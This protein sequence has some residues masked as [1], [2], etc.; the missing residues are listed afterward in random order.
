MKIE[1]KNKMISWEYP[2]QKI[3]PKKLLLRD[4]PRKKMTL[5]RTNSNVLPLD[6]GSKNA[7]KK[8]AGS[9]PVAGHVFSRIFLAKTSYPL[10]V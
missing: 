1:N 9:F 7:S 6:I 2:P 3:I 10:E 5:P 8:E 4:F